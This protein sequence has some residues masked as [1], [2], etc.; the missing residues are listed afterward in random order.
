MYSHLGPPYVREGKFKIYLRP[1]GCK[2]VQ[3]GITLC[4]F[5]GYH[6]ENII[7]LLK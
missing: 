5:G 2:V 4:K 1:E 3:V 6:L 7:L